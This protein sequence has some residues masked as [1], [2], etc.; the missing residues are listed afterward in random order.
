MFRI[1]QLKDKTYIVEHRVSKWTLFGIKKVWKPFVKTS[2]MDCCWHHS[3]LK[4][5]WENFIT[6]IKKQTEIL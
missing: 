5:A 6:E 1:K 2:G 3:E 4:Y